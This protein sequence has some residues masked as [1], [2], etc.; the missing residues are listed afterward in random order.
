MLVVTFVAAAISEEL[1]T[2]FY[3]VLAIAIF[4]LDVVLRANRMAREDTESR[5]DPYIQTLFGQESR[6]PATSKTNTQPKS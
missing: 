5:P 2:A 6:G 1:E 4:V 3:F